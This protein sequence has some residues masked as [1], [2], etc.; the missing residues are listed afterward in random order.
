MNLQHHPWKTTLVHLRRHFVSVCDPACLTYNGF[1]VGVAPL[2]NSEGERVWAKYT[3]GG[4]CPEILWEAEFA[5]TR[6]TIRS[7]SSLP[8]EVFYSNVAKVTLPTKDKSPVLELCE[9][10]PL[11]Y[12]RAFVR[13]HDDL[14]YEVRGVVTADGKRDVYLWHVLH[15]TL[16]DQA[17][18]TTAET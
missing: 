9:G 12:D 7:A 2:F 3:I 17:R 13:C 1:S 14:Q 6:V 11:L 10:Q 4:G 16:T 15:R 5:D 8:C 18:H